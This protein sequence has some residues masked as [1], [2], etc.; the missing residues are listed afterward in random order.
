MR[1]RVF[2]ATAAVLLGMHTGADARTSS[3]SDVRKVREIL[4]ELAFD[5][6]KF[7]DSGGDY[8]TITYRGDDYRWPVYAIGIQADC[9]TM[10]TYTPGCASR[11]KAYM[12]RAPGPPDMTRPRQRGAFLAENL[13]ARHAI[14]AGRIAKVLAAEKVEWLEADFTACS[15]ADEVLGRARNANWIQ[16]L[17]KRR[18]EPDDKGMVEDVIILHADTV[19]VTFNAWLQ[20]STYDGYIAD[21]SPAEWAVELAEALEPCWRPATSTPPWLR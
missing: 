1:L 5:P 15:A 8:V 17:D 19:Q 4:A 2:A 3:I 12:V 20:K 9:P 13:V 11:L 21:G 10:A 16:G 18:G 7:I 6:T 14:T